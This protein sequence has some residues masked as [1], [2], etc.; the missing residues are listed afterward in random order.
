MCVPY[1]G[2]SLKGGEGV[3]GHGKGPHPLSTREENPAEKSGFGGEGTWLRAGK[4]RKEKG[5]RGKKKG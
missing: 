5:E 2:F 3:E 4:G 1:V